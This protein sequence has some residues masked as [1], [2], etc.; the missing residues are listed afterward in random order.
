MSRY[1][2]NLCFCQQTCWRVNIWRKKFKKHS[3]DSY[4]WFK[5]DKGQ[6]KH[7]FGNIFNLCFWHSNISKIRFQS[8]NNSWRWMSSF[9]DGNEIACTRWKIISNTLIHDQTMKSFVHFDLGSTSTF[10]TV[11]FEIKMYFR[12]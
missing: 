6:K 12:K 2:I 7:F 5:H 10:L 11:H 9:P 1:S 3:H 8:T 4:Q